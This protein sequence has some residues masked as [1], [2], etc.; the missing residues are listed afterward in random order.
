LAQEATW[1]QDPLRAW[2]QHAA[3]LQKP[4]GWLALPDWSG[5]FPATNTLRPRLGHKIH[6]PASGP[7]HLGVLHLRGYR[8]AGATGGGFRAKPALDG[9]PAHHK[10][11]AW[12]NTDKGNPRMTIG[13]LNFTWHRHASE[14]LIQRHSDPVKRLNGGTTQ[15]STVNPVSG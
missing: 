12:R 3:D 10:N 9:K 15:L 6:L 14:S 2:A 7:A 13:T 1:Q 4:D 8:N 11:S 5:W